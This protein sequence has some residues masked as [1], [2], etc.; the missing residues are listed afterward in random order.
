MTFTNQEL[1]LLSAEI[2]N[3]LRELG[4]IQKVFERSITKQIRE[5]VTKAKDY[6]NKTIPEKQKQKLEEVTG[7]DAESFVRRFARAAKKD[8]CEESGVLNRQYKQFGDLENES[9]LKIFGG[10]LTGMGFTQAPLQIVVVAVSVI[11]IHLGIKTICE[12]S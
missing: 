4:N 1:Q 10:V 8:L 7:E 3:Q 12:E 9:V 11:V 5:G 2:D 6:N